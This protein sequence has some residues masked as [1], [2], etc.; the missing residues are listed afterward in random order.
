L[1]KGRLAG[2]NGDRV[3]SRVFDG[4]KSEGLFYG[5]YFFENGTRIEGPSF[6]LSWVAGL[7]VSD[8]LGIV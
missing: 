1:G 3:K 5:A 7:D 8:K 2:K 6:D 4:I